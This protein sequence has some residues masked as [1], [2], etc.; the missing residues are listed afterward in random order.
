MKKIGYVTPE[1][2]VLELDWDIYTTS[3][4]LVSNGTSNETDVDNAT[5][6]GGIEW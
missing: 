3:T 1:M 2:E 6:I 4:T 5:N